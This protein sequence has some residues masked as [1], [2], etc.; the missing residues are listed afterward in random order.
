MKLIGLAGKAG[1]GKDTVADILERDHDF[2]RYALAQPIKAALCEAFFLWPA[3]F[4]DRERKERVI[5]WIGK[6]PRQLAQLFGTEFA[7]EMIA[8]DIWLRV[9]QKRYEAILADGVARGFVVSDVRFENEADWIRSNGGVVWHIERP[10]AEPVA[11]HASEEGVEQKGADA[12]IVNNGTI[13]DLRGKVAF[14]LSENER[15]AVYRRA[16]EV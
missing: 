3:D 13:E 9:A 4:T 15:D 6:S 5:S 11:D 10:G 14:L 1:V 8:P 16:G 2:T 12:I 7:R